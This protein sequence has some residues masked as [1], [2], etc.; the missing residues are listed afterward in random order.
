MQHFQGDGETGL[1]QKANANGYKAI[2]QPKALVFHQVLKQRMTY[3]YFDHRYFHQG[4]CDSYSEIRRN[5]GQLIL[6]APKKG[7]IEIIERPLRFIKRAANR[8]V[9]RQTE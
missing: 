7:L 1:T 9:D 4:I 3:E 2:Y 8:I 5:N 6:N